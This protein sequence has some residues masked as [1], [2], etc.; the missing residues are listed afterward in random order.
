MRRLRPRDVD[1]AAA[2]LHIGV[3]ASAAAMA[4]L[5]G[6]RDGSCAIAA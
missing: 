4:R 6:L 1:F 3:A 2:H 5:R